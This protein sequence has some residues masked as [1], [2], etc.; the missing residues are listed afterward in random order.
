MSAHKSVV[1][2]HTDNY[3]LENEIRINSVL[4][5]ITDKILND[6]LNKRCEALYV[7]KYIT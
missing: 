6:K 1:L 3:K 7:S 2:L 4:N 5:I